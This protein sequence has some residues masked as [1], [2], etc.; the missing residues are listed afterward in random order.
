LI[1]Q[2]IA[3]NREAFGDLYERHLAAIYRY[4]FYRVGDRRDAEDL[5]E[6]VFVKAWEALDRYRPTEAPFTAWLYRI[7]HNLLID[8]HRTRRP[9]DALT[10]H[11]PDSAY[12]PEHTVAARE[13]AATV[14]QALAQLEPVHQQ[15][16]SLR[17]LGDLSHAETAQIV[18]KTEG[19]IRVI[20]H[21]A[22]QVLR[23]LLTTQ[24]GE[25]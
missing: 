25:L 15:V 5:T 4:V 12:G 23:Q 24:V 7:A 11:Y 10:D 3:G 22:L 20:Q 13:Q 8:A 16:L 6:T 18:G 14:T 17:F 2:A 19:A 1:A 9:M 21:R